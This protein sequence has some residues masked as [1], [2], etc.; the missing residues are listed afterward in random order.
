MSETIDLIIQ[1]QAEKGVTNKEIEVECGLSN[2]VIS[3]WKNGKSKPSTDAIRRLAA[4][5]SVS[6]DYLLGMKEREIPAPVLT[7]EEQLIL[8]AYRSASTEG[9]FH[10]IQVCMNERKKGTESRVG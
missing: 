8:E 9:R 10:I 6:T 4:Y 3:Q 1:L 5:F 2:A 7:D